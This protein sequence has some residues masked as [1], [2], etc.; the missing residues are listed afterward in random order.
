MASDGKE[1]LKKCFSPRE[2][3]NYIKDNFTVV[4]DSV[5]EKIQP[6]NFQS[7]VVPNKKRYVNSI[8]HKEDNYVSL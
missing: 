8:L 3:D 1:L 4:K 7:L 6:Q 5:L 2:V